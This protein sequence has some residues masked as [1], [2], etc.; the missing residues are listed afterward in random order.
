MD[1]K[2]QLGML[3]LLVVDPIC[4]APTLTAGS[5]PSGK[6][7][8]KV[9]QKVGGI[10]AASLLGIKFVGR[11]EMEEEGQETK[12]TRRVG[13]RETGTKGGNG[14]ESVQGY[15]MERGDITDKR[16]AE[17]RRKERGRAE[18][19]QG[20]EKTSR[21]FGGVEEKDTEEKTRRCCT[22]VGACHFACHFARQSPR[23]LPS[24][25]G[26]EPSVSS[27]RPEIQ[28]RPPEAGSWCC[29]TVRRTVTHCYD[30]ILQPVVQGLQLWLATQMFGWP[31]PF[32]MADSHV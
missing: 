29:W 24:A 27:S 14:R 26:L 16:D 9:C 22:S 3:T 8:G 17:K 15:G 6:L 1:P 13:W 19:E 10:A 25:H 11:L 2:T 23:A 31:H 18:K 21:R 20:R 12:K 30:I 28:D 32:W 5:L 7:W 4:L